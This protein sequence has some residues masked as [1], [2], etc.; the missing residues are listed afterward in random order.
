MWTPA[1]FVLLLASYL[2]TILCYNFLGPRASCNKN[3]A[4]CKPKDASIQDAPPIGTELSTFYVDIVNTVG[5]N[6]KDRR[7]LQLSGDFLHTRASE[8]NLCCTS[9]F[10]EIG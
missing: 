3:Y 10:L 4:V 8:S 6:K 1:L 2:P 7:E 9:L 5:S